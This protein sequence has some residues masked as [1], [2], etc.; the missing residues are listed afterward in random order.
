MY[1]SIGYC[2]AGVNVCSGHAQRLPY[3]PERNM[4]ASEMLK[5]DRGVVGRCFLGDFDPGLEKELNDYVKMHYP[6]PPDDEYTFVMAPCV[7]RDLK[8]CTVEETPGVTPRSSAR[9][10]RMKLGCE[11]DNVTGRTRERRA[12]KKLRIVV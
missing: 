1:F 2:C 9:R 7:D 12:R 6:S 4:Q 10:A 8:A 11:F 3:L 5:W